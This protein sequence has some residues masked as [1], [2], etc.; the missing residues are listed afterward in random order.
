MIGL[1]LVVGDRG[2]T[3]RGILCGITTIPTPASKACLFMPPS[4][5]GLQD[6]LA[7]L[8]LSDSALRQ[9]H[10]IRCRIHSRLQCLDATR[11]EFDVHE[12]MVV[13]TVGKAHCSG[14]AIL[15]SATESRRRS[16]RD[17]QQRQTEH[18]VNQGMD[19]SC[20]CSSTR[21]DITRPGRLPQSHR[22]DFGFSPCR[23]ALPRPE[24]MGQNLGGHAQEE[25][26]S[27]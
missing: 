5:C 26:A 18:Y 13:I 15:I 25:V 14:N 3:L 11:K 22:G 23:L 17:H 19:L 1:E 9:H 16:C 4:T 12:P 2:F 20:F 6:V 21:N 8:G 24:G 27:V 7:N 10:D